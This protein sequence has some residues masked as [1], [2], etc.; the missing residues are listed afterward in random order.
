MSTI[1]IWFILFY[2]P[3]PKTTTQSQ[4]SV[5]CVC[6]IVV[7]FSGQLVFQISHQHHPTNFL[8]PPTPLQFIYFLFAPYKLLILHIASYSKQDWKN[9]GFL[10]P[11]R[12]RGHLFIIRGE[13]TDSTDY[14]YCSIQ[15]FKFYVDD[16]INI[17]IS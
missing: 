10:C 4:N 8:Q 12:E 7:A 9:K 5:L 1:N 15:C 6:A 2:F 11:Q 16:S 14:Y 3:Y 17:A 13:S